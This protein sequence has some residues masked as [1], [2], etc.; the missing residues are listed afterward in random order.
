MDIHI[1][2]YCI[3]NCIH[4]YMKR[5]E[6]SMAGHAFLC[7]TL[8][9]TGAA[10]PRQPAECAADAAGGSRR[11]GPADGDGDVT[12]EGDFIEISYDFMG[13]LDFMRIL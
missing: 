2:V 3:K 5:H 1:H 7:R 12:F 6:V 10:Q 11:G 4:I 13:L 9:G 8:C